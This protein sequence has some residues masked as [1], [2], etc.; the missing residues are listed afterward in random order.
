[1]K[2]LLLMSIL[3]MA[4]CSSYKNNKTGKFK[5]VPLYT[6]LKEKD[7]T[8]DEIG[9]IKK[10]FEKSGNS[11]DGV[12]DGN[13][14]KII[15]LLKQL[16][17]LDT[18]GNKITKDDDKKGTMGQ[19]AVAAV[20]VSNISSSS[21]TEGYSDH[22]GHSDL[23]DSDDSLYQGKKEKVGGPNEEKPKEEVKSNNNGTGNNKEGEGNNDGKGEEKIIEVPKTGADDGNG[24]GSS[25]SD[26]ISSIEVN[27]KASV[28]RGKRRRSRIYRRSKN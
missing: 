20:V 22:S 7:F 17:Y 25:S 8:D 10:V 13:K 14:S 5:K 9:T 18:K 27:S 23:G 26:N 4:G 28:E 12:D 2:K 1:M 16:E 21:S 15:D 6:F 19:M 3:A 11:I 24:A